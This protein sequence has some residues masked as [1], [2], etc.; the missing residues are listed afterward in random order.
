[1]ILIP[2]SSQLVSIPK[3]RITIILM[4]LMQNSI[5]AEIFEVVYIK[6]FHENIHEIEAMR[7]RKISLKFFAASSITSG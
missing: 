7:R 5:L 2:V 1:K 6:K 4:N 3:I